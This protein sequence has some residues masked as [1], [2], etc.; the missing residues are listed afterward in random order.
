M[1]QTLS[2]ILS[3]SIM[4]T[5]WPYTALSETTDKSYTELLIGINERFLDTF[6]QSL[7]VLIEFS[8]DYGWYSD[9]GHYVVKQFED[10]RLERIARDAAHIM[11][12]EPT[13][14]FQL[15]D[16]VPS[17]PFERT[18]KLLSMH[19]ETLVDAARAMA[20]ALETL[21]YSQNNE[22]IF[23][24]YLFWKV[25]TVS[26]L[27]LLSY[28]LFELELTYAFAANENAESWFKDMLL[29]SAHEAT[30]SNFQIQSYLAS[31]LR[32]DKYTNSE[33]MLNWAATANENAKSRFASL[34]RFLE[35]QAPS[36]FANETLNRE[37]NTTRWNPSNLERLKTL[38]GD[39]IGDIAFAR[40]YLEEAIV[41]NE[42]AI[43][44]LSDPSLDLSKD[45]PFWTGSDSQSL[46]NDE[47]SNPRQFIGL[48]SGVLSVILYDL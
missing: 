43:S 46:L 38:E 1:W 23:D 27:G 13:E 12:S 16:T 31:R 41:L 9:D 40:R 10:W 32:G 34:N 26:T 7:V 29:A 17:T 11:A 4:F 44:R 45:S 2:L 24:E 22:S 37:I 5:V 6:E 3:V 15:L 35:K 30:T 18:P 19:A 14:F 47:L 28:N 25:R 20:P 36:V 39:I 8:S 42:R 48:M 21:A 33:K